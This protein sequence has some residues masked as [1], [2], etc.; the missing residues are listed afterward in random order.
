MSKKKEDKISN[1]QYGRT[2]KKIKK[3]RNRTKKMRK[4]KAKKWTVTHRLQDPA[5]EFPST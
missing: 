3:K 1:E 5:K 4:R 2:S